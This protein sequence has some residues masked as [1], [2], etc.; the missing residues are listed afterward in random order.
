MIAKRAIPT[1]A[2]A[3]CLLPDAAEVPPRGKVV[4][5]GAVLFGVAVVP[6]T[7]VVMVMVLLEWAL[8]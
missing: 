4:A 7:S 3:T 8:V 6:L 1:V 2:I 5:C